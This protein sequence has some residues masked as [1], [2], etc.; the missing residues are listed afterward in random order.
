MRCTDCGTLLLG[1]D[2]TPVRH[3]VTELPRVEAEVVE[4]RQHTLTCLDCGKP[5]T[6]EWPVDMPVGQFGPRLQATIGYL[7]GRMGMSQRDVAEMMDVV[8]HTDISLGSITAQEKRVSAAVAAPVQEARSYVQQQAV[9]NVDETSWRE[10]TK[11]CWLWVN[12]TVWVTA[13][14]DN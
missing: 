10:G 8:F 11:R 13:S 4:Y 6:A 9:N 7:T 1:E 3:Q 2:P 12:T 14:N 5:T